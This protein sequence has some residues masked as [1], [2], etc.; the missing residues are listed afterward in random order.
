[1]T[2]RVLPPIPF[3]PF[4]ISS[5]S[6]LYHACLDRDIDPFE[7]L[8]LEKISLNV[9]IKLSKEQLSEHAKRTASLNRFHRNAVFSKISKLI[10][11]YG[12]VRLLAVLERDL[13]DESSL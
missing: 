3:K 11:E 6:N 8:T 9:K 2:Y 4:Y 10:S 5:K 1:M 7:N 12:Y 13:N